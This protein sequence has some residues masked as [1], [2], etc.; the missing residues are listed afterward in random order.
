[1][2]IYEAI[3]GLCAYGEDKQLIT[4][5]DLI[6]CRSRLMDLL[7]LSSYHEAEIVTNDH[8]EI[9][10]T[11]VEYAFENGII[12]S[13][14]PPYSDLFES[15]LMDVLMPKPSEVIIGFRHDYEVSPEE[16][17]D[18]YYQLS[19]DSHYIRLDRTSKNMHWTVDTDFG[20]IDITVNL[21]KP[22]KD[23]KAI[24]AAAKQVSEKYPKCLLCKENE[25][26]AGHVTHPGRHNHRIIPI[27]LKDETWYFQYSPYAYFNEHSIVLK[28]THTPM[29]IDI[30]TFERLFDFVDQ[31]PHYF[32]GS[33]ADLPIVGGSMLAHDHYQSGR[34][35]FAMEKASVVK[36]YEKDQVVIEHLNW[37]LTVLRLKGQRQAVLKLSDRIQKSWLNYSDEGLEILSHTSERHN[38]ITPIARYKN[39]LYE[40]DLVLRNNRTSEVYPQGVFHPRPDV[41]PVKKENIGLIEVMGLAVLPARLKDEMAEIARVCE[42]NLEVPEHL[43][44]FEDI[45][46]QIKEEQR[47]DYYEATKEIVG[48]IFVKGLSDCGVFRQD[49][50]GIEG[51]E[52]FIDQL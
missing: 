32:I 46:S 24:A 6:Y 10:K 50:Q 35:V 13:D 48:Q 14:K 26:F 52:K 16:A 18:N 34:Y 3:A 22:E 5:L 21:S 12:E 37:P 41:H 23:P 27:Q 30:N 4:D 49:D 38:T 36:T 44:N 40:L 15:K 43:M 51:L 39:G 31:F 8:F 33:N 7:N 19:K 42:K 47:E 25:G 28:G 11:M 29:C 1:M 17:T 2:T 45:I 9:L 20:E